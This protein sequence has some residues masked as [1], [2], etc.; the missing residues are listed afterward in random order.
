M[1]ISYP[2]HCGNSPKK[3]LLIKIYE[4]ITIHDDAFIMENLDDKI[5]LNIVA[6]SEISGKENI[7]ATLKLFIEHVDQQNLYL[8]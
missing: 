8:S 7:I 3:S 1:K 2:D 6:D 4:A 5:I